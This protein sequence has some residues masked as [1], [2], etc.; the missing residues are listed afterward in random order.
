MTGFMPLTLASNRMALLFVWVLISLLASAIGQEAVAY[1][2]CKKPGVYLPGNEESNGRDRCES[3]GVKGPA[4]TCLPGEQRDIRHGKP[5]RCYAVKTVT[6]GEKKKYHSY[7]P[8]L[9][10]GEYKSRNEESNGRDRCEGLGFVGPAQTCAVGQKREIRKGRVDRCYTEE[11]V[12]KKERAYRA[13]YEPCSGPGRYDVGS[14]ENNGRDRCVAKGVVGP[15]LTCSPGQTRQIIKGAKD[16]CRGATLEGRAKDTAD[17]VIEKQRDLARRTGE[18]LNALSAAAAG[19]TKSL[20]RVIRSVPARLLG[21]SRQ[22]QSF[23]LSCQKGAFVEAISG[24]SNT[25][26][27]TR[28]AI[29]CAAFNLGTGQKTGGS[30]RGGRGGDEG[31]YFARTCPDGQALAAFMA[32][33]MDNNQITHLVPV[34]QS[35]TGAGED[36]AVLDAVATEADRG[37][38]LGST[39][40]SSGR[41]TG[42]KGYASDR[43]HA[44]ELICVK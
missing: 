40:C 11:P 12:K 43:I 42:L 8:C 10:P 6:T 28:L 17:G 5:D 34:C 38:Q 9:P 7:K 14:E 30:W 37:E 18:Q 41:A 13:D 20:L 31:T 29:K 2:P 16:Q 19:K 25:G 33:R 39:G 26:G 3:P 44:V 23:A 21:T 24:K 15:A 32:V 27:V 22:G 35:V 36:L 4:L 1:E